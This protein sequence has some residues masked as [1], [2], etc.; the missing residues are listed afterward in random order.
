MLMLVTRDLMGAAEIQSR[1]GGV[2]RQRIQ[3]IVSRS[4]FPQPVAVIGGGRVK[5]WET[6]DVEKWIAEHRP[7]DIQEPTD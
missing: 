6:A 4:D 5:V 3:Q 7:A 1:L 2:S